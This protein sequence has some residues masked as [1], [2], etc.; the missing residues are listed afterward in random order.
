MTEYLQHNRVQL[1]L[2]ALKGG[3]G[4]AL[5]LLHGLGERSPQTLPSE[6]A[7]WPGPVY[8]LDFTGHGLSTVPNGGGYTCEVLMADAD[9]ALAR[10]GSATVVGRGLGAYIALLIA[11]ARPDRVRG[12]ILLDGPGLAGGGSTSNPYIPMVDTTQLAPPDP[13]A[14][15]EL[16]TDGRPPAYASHF[17]LLAEQRSD[18]ARPLSICT[19]EQPDWLSVVLNVIAADKTTLVNALREYSGLSA[20]TQI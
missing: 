20:P 16:A 8:A 17:A 4:L 7:Q 14:I 19:C 3:E 12:A 6:Y 11:G 15:A 1:A 5:L 10:I 13:F 2:H 9:T 18:L